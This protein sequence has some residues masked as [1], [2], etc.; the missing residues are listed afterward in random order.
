MIKVLYFKLICLLICTLYCF[1]TTNVMAQ[2]NQEFT[3][4][5]MD[6][7]THLIILDIRK[8]IH[9]SRTHNHYLSYKHFEKAANRA[10]Q[11]QT[12]DH[13]EYAMDGLAYCSAQTGRIEEAKE[14]SQ[15]AI[16][17]CEKNFPTRYARQM[18]RYLTL[19]NIYLMIGDYY[20]A[21]NIYTKGIALFEKE[22]NARTP[23]SKHVYNNLGLVY[24]NLREEE[25][26]KKNMLKAGEIYAKEN[27][28]LAI[29]YTYSNIGM[30]YYDFNKFDSALIYYHP[31]YEQIS[32][33]NT[34]GKRD[35]QAMTLCNI[36]DCY[37]ALGQNQ[38]A[39]TSY[40]EVERILEDSLAI[41]PFEKMHFHRR[42][43]LFFLETDP[44]RA[45]QEF[46]IAIQKNCP[47][48]EDDDF[49]TLPP[50]ENSINDEF[51]A[52]LLVRRSKAIKYLYD[53]EK[54]TVDDL[55]S[56]H[57]SILLFSK[58]TDKRRLDIDARNS[59]LYLSAKSSDD[60]DI[61]I[62]IAF[63]LFQTTQDQKFLEDA[64][65]LAEKNKAVSLRESKNN[66]DTEMNSILPDSLRRKLLSL[67][68]TVALHNEELL[69]LKSQSD[70]IS[71]DSAEIE[72][73]LITARYKY[74]EFQDYLKLNFKGYNQLKFTNSIRSISEIQQKLPDDQTA[75]LEFFVGNEHLYVFT[76]SKT[77][78]HVRS[79]SGDSTTMALINDIHSLFNQHTLSSSALAKRNQ[80]LYDA[81]KLLLGTDPILYPNGN[82]PSPITDLIIVPDNEINYLSFEALLTAEISPSVPTSQTPWLIKQF[83]ISYAQSATLWLDHLK[84]T[85]FQDELK[86][87]AFAPTSEDELS[88]FAM[89]GEMS[90]LRDHSG[91]LPG[92][93]SEVKAIAKFL[94][95]KFF[96]GREA[97]ESA[98]KRELKNN[99]SII[100][101]ATH[102][103]A[104]EQNPDLSNL[105]FADQNNDE[106]NLLHVYEMNSIDLSSELVVLSA[107]ETS[108]GKLIRGE[109]IQSLATSFIASGA[110]S[111][112]T[113]LWKVEDHA[114]QKI[115]STFYEELDKGK[116]RKTALRTAKLAYLASADNL[117]SHPFYWASFVLV[118]DSRPLKYPGKMIFWVILSGCIVFIGGLQYFMKYQ[119]SS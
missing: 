113:S 74:H 67:K 62:G 118:G 71:S 91:A 95:G 89:R 39:L 70:S 63:E 8:A 40:Q 25:K 116:S 115:M 58:L 33:E 34:P 65:M 55:K 98:F 110:S 28:K 18:E 90:L 51:L 117:T 2:S 81:F 5:E 11:L 92:A 54:L 50:Y 57:N 47:E 52:S 85:P 32:N 60:L 43:G 104:N 21:R 61:G 1:P 100:H 14:W 99:Y 111:V 23:K 107:C 6:S 119:K 4:A 102:A 79:L 31:Y 80:L 12:L 7:L 9:L 106:D 38:K 22:P 72:Q 114:T 26:A 59:K 42:L 83:E 66:S 108:G 87:L 17:M 96:L 56:A 29:P 103:I 45:L 76:I 101:L 3:T 68:A 27:Q 49:R 20:E 84:H 109:G 112:I 36:A 86:C 37:A 35:I 64:F 16:R 77:N 41:G 13:L 46:Q 10:E 93:L 82:F 44:A 88:E 97:S 48:Y 105:L 75:F 24:K 30:L 15:K 78:A 73:S 53:E 94:K 69:F 19:G